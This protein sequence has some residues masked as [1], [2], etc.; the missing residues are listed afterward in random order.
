MNQ[1]FQVFRGMN[2]YDKLNTLERMHIEAI[3]L[4]MLIFF[5][6]LS[7]FPVSSDVNKI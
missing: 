5:A 6:P 3:T 2:M 1:N 4:V 7:P